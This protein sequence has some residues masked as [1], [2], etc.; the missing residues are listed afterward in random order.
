MP[1]FRSLKLS[2]VTS[3]LLTG[4]LAVVLLRQ[5]YTALCSVLAPLHGHRCEG[6]LRQNR[7][8][9]FA[10][11]TACSRPHLPR[12]AHTIPHHTSMQYDTHIPDITP[13]HCTLHSQTAGHVNSWANRE[14][15]NRTCK[16]LGK[17]TV[18][19]RDIDM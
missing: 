5:S 15:D 8:R 16:H 7:T 1:V 10:Q 13:A 14:S 9:T 11:R 12:M 2:A 17:K 4:C 6:T 3:T 18:R 19:Q